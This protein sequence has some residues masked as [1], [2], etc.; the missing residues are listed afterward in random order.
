MSFVSRSAISFYFSHRTHI[1][2]EVDRLD[3]I[4]PF[5]EAAGYGTVYASGPLKKHGCLVAFRADKYERAGAQVVLYDSAERGASHR[6]K[7]I[8]SLVA[9]HE[10]GLADRGLVVA[11]T[12]LFWHPAFVGLA[13]LPQCTY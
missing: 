1:A 6:T 9:L 11:T 4:Q 10:R 8:G 2:Q 7:N 13:K 12:H 3:K 5:L